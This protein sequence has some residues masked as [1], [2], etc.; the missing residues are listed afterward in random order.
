MDTVQVA[1]DAFLRGD[2]PAMLEV[3]APD[4]IVTQSPDQPDIQDYHGYEGLRQVMAEWIGSWDDWSIE[5]LSAREVGQLVL[6]TALQKGRG[7][8]SGVPFET[9][10]AFVFTVSEGMITRWQMFLS[11]QQ[12]VEAIERG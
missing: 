2:E 3:V 6:A 7:K 1:V 12:A 9:E 10:V 4:V 5:I 11:E 8:V